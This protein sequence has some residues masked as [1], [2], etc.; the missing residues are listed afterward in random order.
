MSIE[1]ALP[2]EGRT[3]LV[4][5]GARGL[6][7][8]TAELLASL[9]CAVAVNY[10]RSEAAAVELVDRIR[11]AG[12]RAAAVQ[13]DVGDPATPRR[14]V[15]EVER[16]LGAGIDILVN[17]AGPFVRERRRFADAPEDEL[18]AMIQGN[19]LGAMRLD[20]L[21]I[22][23]MRSRGWGRIVH[24]GFG[25][26][27]EARGWPHRAA[28]AAAK[29]GLVSFTKTLSTEEAPFGITVNM[30]CPGDIRG[31][32]KEK[33]IADVRHLIDPE[34]PRGRPGAGED[35]ARVVAFLCDPASDYVT[36]NIIEVSGGLDPIRNHL[37]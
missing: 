20:R 1:R 33:R 19:L 4:T 2:L 28:Y 34:S 12:G 15:G 18:E 35:V 37:P 6:G 10:V 8:M 21:V 22:P 17:N 9:G 25:R 36:G 16:E 13:G 31:E 29:V 23:G 11:A 32:L 5:G 14:L 24:F 7:R 3:A 30:V 26:S 27:A